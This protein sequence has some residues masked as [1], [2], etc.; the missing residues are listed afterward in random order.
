MV[1]TPDELRQMGWREHSEPGFA[2]TIQSFWT[3]DA[4]EGKRYGLLVEAR[5]LN[6]NGTLHG[7]AL[8]ALAD[9]ALG[10]TSS[11]TTGGTKQATI[12]LGLDFVA[13]AYEN[14]FVSVETSVTRRTRSIVF[15]NAVLSVEDRIVATASGLWKMLGR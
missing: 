14:E 13:P 10:Y 3:L 9:H 2:D 11:D 7:G 5:L 8:L 4:P 1:T 12:H 15:V 6:R